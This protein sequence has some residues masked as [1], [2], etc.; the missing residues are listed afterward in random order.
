MLDCLYKGI[1]YVAIL[2]RSVFR[3]T[4]TNTTWDSLESYTATS[5]GGMFQQGSSSNR[6]THGIQVPSWNCT[7]IPLRTVHLGRTDRSTTPAA[8]SAARGELVHS[9]TLVST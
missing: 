2:Q 8:R 3:L 6:M 9:R 4:R 1:A 5:T 7:A